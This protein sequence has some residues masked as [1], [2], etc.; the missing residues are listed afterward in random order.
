MSE[1]VAM[2]VPK[3]QTERKIYLE[4]LCNLTDQ[5]EAVTLR[6]EEYQISIIHSQANRVDK[7]P[8]SDEPS[9]TTEPVRNT[10]TEDLDAIIKGF[11]LR[12]DRCR[13]AL[14]DLERF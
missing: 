10:L 1:T 7:V 4:K 14:V 6:I 11:N 13:S 2:G 5:L 8:P 9:P 3:E 12:L